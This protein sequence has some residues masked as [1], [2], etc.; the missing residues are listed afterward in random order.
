[1]VMQWKVRPV[2]GS[3]TGQVWVGAG[4]VTKASGIYLGTSAEQSN[5]AAAKVWMSTAKE[6]VI[7][8]TGKRGSG[9]S[10]TL[11]VIAEGLTVQGTAAIGAIALHST[12]RAV[13]F[14]DP[15]DLY[16][17]L[18]LPVQPS[19]N[20]EVNEQYRLAH[21][22]GLDN[23]AFNVEA[24]VP[25][26]SNRRNADPAWFRT[27]SIPV[28]S[29]DT[30]EWGMLLGGVSQS[31][32]MGQVLCDCIDRVRQQNKNDYDLQDL[33]RVCDSAG[34]AANYQPETCRAL[35]QR[36]LGLGRTGLLTRAGTSLK[37]LLA[38]GRASVIL[39]N[40]LSQPDREI[41]VSV[42]TRLL[43]GERQAAS[44]VEKRL[45]FDM[46]LTPQERTEL[47][48]T[49]PK[50]APKTFIIMDE[51]HSFLGPGSRRCTRDVFTQIAKE[52]RN[53]GVSLAVATQQP[54]AIDRGVLSQVELFIS[55][56]LVTESDIRSVIDN[57]KSPLPESIM[58]GS[59]SQD[60]S[61]AFRSIGPGYCIISASDMSENPKRALFAC[62][63]PRSSVHGGIEV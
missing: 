11:G 29:L 22:S 17:T 27:L 28:S 41:V 47:V 43:I 14:F 12:Q 23:N 25:G 26:V 61:A 7:A 56:Q 1:M 42:L 58:F 19:P 55:H 2:I 6:Q 46:T 38:P 5:G 40:R 3:S 20:N 24:W 51:A 31:D 9:K 33:V 60:T 62:I 15:L 49:L 52:G 57:M 35:R 39:L 53:Y 48:D 8:I 4:C 10:F 21:A 37:E 30:E 45:A 63:R 44:A 13:L 59:Q 34:I 50:M 54:S 16:W 36:L 32:P 18:R